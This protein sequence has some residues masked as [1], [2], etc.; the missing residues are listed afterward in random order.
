MPGDHDV[1]PVGRL[2]DGQMPVVHQDADAGDLA[3]ED[4]RQ[5]LVIVA[6]ARHGERRGEV[7]EH[8]HDERAAQVAGDVVLGAP[9]Q[10]D[11]RLRPEPAVRVRQDADLDRRFHLR[12]ADGVSPPARDAAR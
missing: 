8:R 4:Q 11:H 9:G 6:V 10:R 1:G 3:E 12:P 7:G 2:V 5:R